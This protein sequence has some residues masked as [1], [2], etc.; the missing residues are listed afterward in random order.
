[1][2]VVLT[3]LIGVVTTFVVTFVI[4]NTLAHACQ[5]TVAM[6]LE[7]Q[8]SSSSNQTEI[9]VARTPQEKPNLERFN[10]LD[11]DAWNN[12]NWTL[13][14]EIH[15]PDVLVVDF[16]GNRNKRYRTASPMGNGGDVSSLR[17]AEYQLIRSR[18]R[19]ATGLPSQALYLEIPQ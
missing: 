17:K 4:G 5:S 14:R 16:S 2:S 18:L 10:Q 15:A 8:T 13:F 6:A 3:V 12:R 9:E 19:Q 1:M 7:Q 11:F